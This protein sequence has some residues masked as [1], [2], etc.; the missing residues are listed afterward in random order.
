MTEKG[1]QGD[2]PEE[3]TRASGLLRHIGDSR[4]KQKLAE[5]RW[6]TFVQQAFFCLRQCVKSP[7]LQYPRKDR[8]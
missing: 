5:R 4:D 2:I 1:L 7:I 8:A 6:I 3:L